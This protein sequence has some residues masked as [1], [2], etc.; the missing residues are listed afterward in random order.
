MNTH[1]LIIGRAILVGLAVVLATFGVVVYLNQTAGADPSLRDDP[2]TFDELNAAI[3]E[4]I[5]CIEDA[6]MSVDVFPAEGLRPTA[7]RVSA[8]DADGEPDAETVRAAQAATAQCNDALLTPVSDRW[9]AL[10]PEPSESEIQTLYD[11]L[12]ACVASGGVPD[13]PI[14]F[15]TFTVYRNAPADGP[16][17]SSEDGAAYIQCAI[18]AQEETG[19]LAPP[20]ER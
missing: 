16:S 19:L 18:G 12:E 13:E 8:S 5:S 20:I 15:G 17:V 7:F 4:T 1:S 14:R 6:G 2:V 9:R 11:W 3:S 10:Q